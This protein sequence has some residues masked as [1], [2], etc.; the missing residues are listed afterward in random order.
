MIFKNND[1]VYHPT[2]GNG[3]VIIVMP[4]GS[5]PV[6]VV[7]NNSGDKVFSF[8]KRGTY[9]FNN[10]DLLLN[11]GHLPAITV[12]MHRKLRALK[13]KYFLNEVYPNWMT[14]SFYP[15][16]LKL[17]YAYYVESLTINIDE[18]SKTCIK[19]TL[20]INYDAYAFFDKDCPNLFI[21]KEF[22]IT[23]NFSKFFRRNM[24]FFI[25]DIFAE[26]YAEFEKEMQEELLNMQ[27]GSCYGP[28]EIYNGFDYTFDECGFI[29]LS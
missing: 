10:D 25:N 3:I 21:R 9:E 22:T 17:P 23:D 14:F 26:E 15:K 12:K 13:E 2:F 20:R 5:F 7:F 27:E 24:Q 18:V 16:N 1:R 28:D 4:T 19:G 11:F 6:R 8:T 29:K